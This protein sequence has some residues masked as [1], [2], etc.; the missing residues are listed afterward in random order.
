MKRRAFVSG[1]AAAAATAASGDRAVAQSGKVVWNLPHVAAPSYYHIVNLNALAAKVKEKSGDRMEIRV[2]PASSLYPGP[3][4]IPAVLD[5]RAEIA[6]IISPYLTDVLLETGVLELPFMT[7]TL[8][9]HRKALTALRPFITEMTARRG[10][11]LMAVYGWPSQQLFSTQPVRT[12]AD[13]KGKKV[14]VTGAETSD[15]V[16]LVGGAPV[17][18]GFAEVYTSLQRGVID[19]AITTAT[20]AEPMKFF[21][22]AKFL[23]YWYFSGAATELLVVNQ[24]AWDKLSPDLQKVVAD[25]VSEVQLEEKEWADV[26]KLDDTARERVKALGMTVID[27]LPE[28]IAKARQTARHGWD[29][30]LKRTG[31]NG[32]R[33][34]ELAQKA[35]GRT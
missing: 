31:S 1:V 23:N 19:G 13:W 32:K 14:R 33:A 34:M 10:L 5:G 2:H 29:L 4:L 16:K 35:I 12:I 15:F 18:M 6:P 17:G 8:D 25:A 22:V 9:E 11:K 24:K 20:N 27:P 7:Q 28:D 21:E 26:R 30:W 3:E